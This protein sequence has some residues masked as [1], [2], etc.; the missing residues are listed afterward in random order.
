[1]ALAAVGGPLNNGARLYGVSYSFDEDSV[2]DAGRAR[3]MNAFLDRHGDDQAP[4]IFSKACPRPV[5]YL[6]YAII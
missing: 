2:K 1:M 4:P 3:S 5:D 6:L